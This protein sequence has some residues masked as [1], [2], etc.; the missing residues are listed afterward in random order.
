MPQEKQSW[1]INSHW[2]WT[3]KSLN[4]GIKQGLVVGR[5]G[6]WDINPPHT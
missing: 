3:K 2:E 4:K 1:E 5:G 6:F